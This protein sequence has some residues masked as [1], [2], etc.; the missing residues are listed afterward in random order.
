MEK[1]YKA[2]RLDNGKWEEFTLDQIGGSDHLG[3]LYVYD[4]DDQ[5]DCQK[6]LDKNTICQYTGISDS[7]GNRIFEGDYVQWGCDVEPVVEYVSYHA[8][9]AA[10]LT[11]TSCMEERLFLLT[12]DN[13]HDRG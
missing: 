10:F 2:K 9:E 6:L 4:I 11:E 8:K 13:I 12:G 5:D 7:E 1:I 3:N